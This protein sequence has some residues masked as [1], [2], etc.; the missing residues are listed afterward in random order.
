MTSSVPIK[1]VLDNTMG[2]QLIGVLLAAGSVIV[3]CSCPPSPLTAPQALWRYLP[4]SRTSEH[5]LTLCPVSCTQTWYYFT[6]YPKD[7]IGL[8]LLVSPIVPCRHALIIVSRSRSCGYLIHAT[9]PSLRILVSGSSRLPQL[10]GS[11][12]FSIHLPREELQQPGRARQP[13]LVRLACAAPSPSLTLSCAGVCWS[14]FC[15]TYA[16]LIGQADYY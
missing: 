6:L 9:R 2:A 7:R 10:R 1:L 4:V 5:A 3:L 11:Y 14:R 15:S 13:R 12:I 16:S 8:R